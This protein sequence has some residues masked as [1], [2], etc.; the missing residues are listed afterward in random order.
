[1]IQNTST[2]DYPRLSNSCGSAYR[3]RQPYCTIE[4]YVRHDWPETLY[5]R[6]G[7]F[8]RP[9]CLQRSPYAVWRYKS[10]MRYTRSNRLNDKPDI[11]FFC[12]GQQW[13]PNYC[14][15]GNVCIV[16]WYINAVLS[17]QRN[18]CERRL[19]TKQGRKNL[20]DTHKK[21]KRKPLLKDIT[22][23]PNRLDNSTTTIYRHTGIT[24]YTTRTNITYSRF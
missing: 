3:F 13:N 8:T 5:P 23:V 22:V 19:R 21:D 18:Y 11:T 9:Q 4:E 1:M 12:I 20:S 24:Y 14:K 2:E 6:S 7:R 16:V 17:L 10:K 15:C